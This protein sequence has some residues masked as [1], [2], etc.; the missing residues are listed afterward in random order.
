[1]KALNAGTTVLLADS[2]RAASIAAA[3]A[4]HAPA[5]AWYTTLDELLR[6]QPLGSV[7]VLILHFDREPKGILLSLLARIALEF[8]GIQ[9]VASLQGTPSLVVAEHLTA[10]G[11]ELVWPSAE[12]PGIDG[13]VSVVDRMQE[14]SQWVARAIC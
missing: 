8:P 6:E 5:F 10:C 2:G 3:L 14:R 12:A 1:M 11:I 4:N 13:L 9:M 7:S